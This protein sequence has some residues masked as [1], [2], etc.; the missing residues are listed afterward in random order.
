MQQLFR[1]ILPALGLFI[2]LLASSSPAHARLCTAVVSG[3]NWSNGNTWS[4]GSAPTNNDTIWIPVGFTVF[5]DINS[6][7]Y[8]NMLV[9]VDGTLNF[10]NGQKINICPGGVYVSPTGTLEGGTPGSKINIC[11]STVWNGPG[12]TGGPASFG[13]VVLPIELLSF[14]ATLQENGKVKI[15]WA[16]ATETNNDFFTVERS[17]NGMTFEAIARVEGA[18]KSSTRLDY[19]AED[20]WPEQGTNYYR[21]RQTDINGNSETFQIVAVNVVRTAAGCELKVTPNPCVPQCTVS[22]EG[23]DEAAPADITLDIVDAAGQ[24]VYSTI[25]VRDAR[26]G[27]SL[28]IDASNNLKPGVYVVRGVS[29]REQYAKKF[30]AK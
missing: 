25:P 16:T 14:D 19:T 7:T 12:P 3:G 1:G 4:C 27:F 13:N 28:T 8:S 18:G 5:V 21:L 15:E 10:G 26:G 30:V 23:C 29:N 11:G 20:P 6:P 22:L 17:T 2:I 24:R 9:V